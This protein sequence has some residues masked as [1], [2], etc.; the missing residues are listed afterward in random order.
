MNGSVWPVVLSIVVPV[1]NEVDGV[2]WCYERLSEALA[3]GPERYRDGYELI[4]VDDGSTDG[5]CDLC[6][7]LHAADPHIR[8]I[9]FQRNFGKTAALRAGFE[10]CRG[11]YVVTIDADLQEEP[12]EIFRLLERLDAGDDLV[13]GWRRNRRDPPTK[14]LPSRVFNWVVSVVTGIRLHDFN[15]GLKAYRRQVVDNLHLYGSQH[16]FVPLLAAQMGYRVTEVP[17]KHRPRRFG[18]SKYG[19]RRL[20]RGYLDFIQVLFITSYLRQPLRLFGAIGS[21]MG[22]AGALILAYLTV[23]WILGDRPIGDR[24]LLLLGLLLLLSGFQILCTGLVGEMMRNAS[25]RA[26]AEFVI[27][28]ELGID[29]E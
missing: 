24:P 10:R 18:K 23:L 12:T 2:R 8:V 29:Y 9:Q 3:S 13:S 4:L 1:Y 27:R 25:S 20:G 16:R 26:E 6:G 5:S 17:V 11:E 14:T 28:Q 7:D 21:A 15:C 19:F 22:A